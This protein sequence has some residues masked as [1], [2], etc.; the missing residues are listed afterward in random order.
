VTKKYETIVITEEP[1]LYKVYHLQEQKEWYIK[2]LWPFI[3][4]MNA[5]GWYISAM[6]RFIESH[7]KQVALTREVTV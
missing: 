7:C 1:P 4:E 2:K 3:I 6:D 5:Q